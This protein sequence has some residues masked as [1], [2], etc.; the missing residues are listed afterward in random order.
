MTERGRCVTR[1]LP[2]AIKFDDSSVGAL[3]HLDRRFE[4]NL[5]KV[6]SEHRAVP[7]RLTGWLLA[8]ATV[9]VGDGAVSPALLRLEIIDVLLP[10]RGWHSGRHR[11]VQDTLGH[12][13]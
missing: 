3:I 9:R 8:G 13:D 6:P 4:R 2:S 10:S 11:L 1:A 7:V 5:S 12:V